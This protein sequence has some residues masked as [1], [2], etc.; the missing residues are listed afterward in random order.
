MDYYTRYFVMGIATTL[1][2]VLILFGVFE[3]ARKYQRNIFFD[4]CTT[5]ESIKIDEQ[6]YTCVKFSRQ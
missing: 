5:Y 1:T 4:S 6:E 3:L 2:V